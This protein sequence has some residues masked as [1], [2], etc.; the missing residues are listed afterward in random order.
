MAQ[1]V[2][3]GST[4]GSSLQDLLLCD[5]IQPGV[6]ASYQICK[7]IYLYHPIGKKM[8]ESPIA[9]AQFKPREI[10]LD[11]GPTEELIKAFN[12]QWAKDGHTKTIRSVATQARAYGVTSVALLDGAKPDQP[13]NTKELAG[14]E[15]S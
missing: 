15:I 4:L 11:D 3:K 7:S 13:L 2:L 1:L 10:S 5:D 12:D 14:K 8:A 9:M 6:D